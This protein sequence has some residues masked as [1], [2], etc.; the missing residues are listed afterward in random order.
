MERILQIAWERWQINGR[1]NGDL[2]ARGVTTLFYFTILVPFAIG[3][4]LF[5]DPLAL[6]TQKASWLTRKPVG[7]NLDS[8]KEQ[9]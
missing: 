9:F 1:I 5:V 6:K 3:A 8:A 4:Q 2:I 7:T